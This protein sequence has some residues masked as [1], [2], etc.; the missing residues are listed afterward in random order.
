MPYHPKLLSPE[1]ILKT[2][3]RLVEHGNADSLSLRAVAGDLGVKAPSL[4]R[5][6]PDKESLEIALGQDILKVMLVAFRKASAINDPDTTFRRMLDVYLG[7]A[8]NRFRLYAFVMQHRHAERYGSSAGK[9]VH[10]VIVEAA[11]A[12]SGE[13]DYLDDLPRKRQYQ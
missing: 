8:R 10:N 5:Y 12:V 9:A 3:L 11:S 6:L 7:F 4:Y 2:A 13:Q 1:R